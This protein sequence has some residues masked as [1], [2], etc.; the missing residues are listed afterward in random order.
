MISDTEKGLVGI[1][2]FCSQHLSIFPV[3]SFHVKPSSISSL[4]GEEEEEG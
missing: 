3:I 4:R 1:N 2:F